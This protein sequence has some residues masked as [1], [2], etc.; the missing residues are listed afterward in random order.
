MAQHY[1][2]HQN[3]QAE[4]V[5]LVSSQFTRV[6]GGGGVTH[7]HGDIQPHPGTMMTPYTPPA[8]WEPVKGKKLCSMDD[9][10]AYPMKETGYCAGH[11]RSL[12][13]R[14]NWP[15]GGNFVGR[16]E[17]KEPEDEAV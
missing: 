5:S 17:E 13:L 9:C 6:G 8:R 16:D 2:T 14:D 15:K 10:R 12:G 11:T 3:A 7:A 1:N 4:G